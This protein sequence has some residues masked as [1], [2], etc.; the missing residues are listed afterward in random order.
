M[1]RA[2]VFIVMI[3]MAAMLVTDVALVACG[4]KFLR[5]GRGAARYRGAYAAVYPASI[6]IYLPQADRQALDAL[7]A[8]L[9]R[10]GH[11]PQ[12]I[13]N[14]TQL[15]SH[16]GATRADI[17]LTD[18]RV[19]DAVGSL[20]GSVAAPPAILPVLDKSTKTATAAAEKQYGCLI[21]VTTMNRDE[22]L[23]EIDHVMEQRTRAARQ[24]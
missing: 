4:D 7:E 24:H 9:T 13:T 22:A 2:R 3:A 17:I 11:S 1:R 21:N 8:M 18:I 12:V 15:A 14:A 23:G 10:A 16:A 6:L 20:V 5:T 19:A